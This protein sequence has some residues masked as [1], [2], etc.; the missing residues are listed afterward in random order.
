MCWGVNRKH[1]MQSKMYNCNKG[2]V[3]CG[4]T[5][6]KITVIISIAYM[7]LLQYSKTYI[8]WLQNHLFPNT[9]ILVR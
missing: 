3:D 2:E 5:S 4:N 8:E 7:V 9:H 1:I 6:S